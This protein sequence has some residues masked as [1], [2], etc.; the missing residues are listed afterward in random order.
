LMFR[1]AIDS[2]VTVERGGITANALS[3]S[4]IY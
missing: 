4:G 3:S 1:A 2:I